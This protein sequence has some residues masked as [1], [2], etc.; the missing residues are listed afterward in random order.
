M[1][2]T[3]MMP[4]MV[5]GTTLTSMTT[6]TTMV[7]TLTTMRT[8]SMSQ[9]STMTT[10]I[11]NQ[12]TLTSVMSQPETSG[13]RLTTSMHGTPSGIRSPTK[14]D[15][16]L[17][18]TSWSL[19]RHSEK[20]SSTS[21]TTSTISMTASPT[22]TRTSLRTT[23]VSTTTTTKSP[24]TTTRSPTRSTE[25]RDSRDSAEE[26]RTT[27]TKTETSLSSTASS[28]PSP[29]TWLV[30]APTSSPAEE[31]LSPT[32]HSQQLKLAIIEQACH[33][34]RLQNYYPHKASITRSKI[35]VTY[36]ISVMLIDFLPN[37][38]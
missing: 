34:W 1:G 32:D 28:S 22:T 20:S 3:V 27:S 25:L 36:H 26:A 15:S 35:F 10:T 29:R 31:P 8:Q 9:S 24:T 38:A 33:V 7:M 37:T 5:P 18:P 13:I 2:I 21:I 11:C 6:S 17:R 23:K 12:R 16:N 14:R 4:M 19:S 30:P